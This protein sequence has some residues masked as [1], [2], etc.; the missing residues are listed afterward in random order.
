MKAGRLLTIVICLDLLACAGAALADGGIFIRWPDPVDV[1]QPTQK[2]YIR[3]DGSQEKMLIQTKYEGPAEEMVWIV[4][5]PSE[6][7]VEMGNGIVFEELSGRTDWPDIS[8]T[9]FAG[10][11][12]RSFGPGY[13]PTGGS[14]SGSAGGEQVVQWRQRIGEYDVALLRP[15]DSQTVIEWLNANGFAVP[16]K[17]IPA[18]QGYIG[19]QWWMVAA[20][21]HP[22]ALTAITQKQLAQGLLHPLEM[23]F[24]SSSCLFPMRLTSIAAGPVEE[25]IYIE[26]P[27]H[28]EP[29]TFADDHWV[30]DAFDGP[31]R[32]VPQWRY[33]SDVE[34]TL[35]TR[36]GHTETWAQPHLTK[37]RRVFLPEE[38]TQD[39]VFTELDYAKWLRDEDTLHMGAA[40]TQYG[41]SRDP[42]AVSHLSSLLRSGILDLDR[43]GFGEY[44]WWG[45]S[46]TTL[47][48]GY[49]RW[50]LL[51]QHILSAIWAIGE[52]G[53]EYP[54][55]GEVE[56]MLLGDCARH[57]N[58]RVRMEGYVALMKLR[59]EQLG[60]VLAERLASIPLQ[61]P[62][63]DWRGDSTLV[64]F[65]AEMN[66][67]ADW[68]S[69]FGTAEQKDALVNAL[70]G[71][72]AKLQGPTKD[73]RVGPQQSS[74]AR[75]DW[76][77]WIVWRAACAQDARL[78]G[79]LEDLHAR[80]AQIKAAEPALAF[81]LRAQAACGSTGALEAVRR[82]ID[83]DRAQFLANG[84][85]PV[86][87]NLASLQSFYLSRYNQN[88]PGSL[89]VQV[90]QQHWLRY[91]LYPMPSDAAD[92]VLRL[93]LSEEGLSDWYSLY[94][95]AAIKSPRSEDRDRLL[96]MWNAGD[97]WVRLIV[98][99]V[100][101]AWNDWQT[102][103][104]LYE[105]S[106]SDEVRSEIAWA[107]ADLGVAQ[108]TA[109]VEEQVLTAWNSEWIAADR[110]FILRT[111][112]DPD[113]DDVT[114]ID[115]FRK[116]EAIWVYFHPLWG[117]LDNERLAML[118]RLT[119]NDA[120]HSGL[121]F[122]LLATKYTTVESLATDYA[123]K[124]WAQ[125]LLRK[126]AADVLEDHPAASAA[127]TILSKTDAQL[128]VDACGEI[129]S[130]AARRTLLINLLASG[131]GAYMPVIGGLLQQVWP[132]RYIE[133]EGQSILFREPGDLT[134]SIDYYCANCTS[135]WLYTRTAETM[136]KSIITDD[137]LPAGYRAFLLACWRTA[138]G[139]I[140][141][142]FVESLLQENM[143]DFIREALERRLPDWPDSL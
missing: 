28:Y 3:W 129:D 6:P 51:G 85:T 23:T 15:V 33:M 108:A 45:C 13:V 82:E 73:S 128:L 31:V 64:D 109:I 56:E 141:E 27:T 116:A 133:T 48:D 118:K 100:L 81:V 111:V 123:R 62:P 50:R 140:S 77:E 38:M 21:I 5:V 95:L 115:A 43:Y 57:T 121:R 142:G 58:E 120:V 84:E 7:A 71:S 104:S 9:E 89:R 18:L 117:A 22:D 132:Q 24:Q 34:L 90:L 88:A 91:A 65:A 30:I 137:S 76:F 16:D 39:I 86:W 29:L 138:P 114:M 11:W 36:E 99:D 14:F 75:S 110:T 125:P 74:P 107:L 126:A 60:P 94:L 102:L 40:A 26:G 46:E 136:L 67:A 72:I 124:D 80:L 54:V 4:P 70:A 53:I 127:A 20:K 131:S 66:I 134:P 106:E 79:P 49:A 78:A 47:P 55:G 63:P 105:R 68:I 113:L 93:A 69:R 35:E 44:L 135:H 96:Q 87:E 37:L 1:L 143:P 12:N 101:Y 59:S 52:I 97:R 83:S 41:R 119:G 10:L 130:D 42:N 25:L 103:M 122:E 17:A 8:Y 98:T 2:V 61:G 19:E 32:Q 92:G 112:V 139:W